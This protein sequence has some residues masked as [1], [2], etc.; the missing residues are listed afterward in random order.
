[1]KKV[2]NMLGLL[3]AMHICNGQ[4]NIFP[5]D[6]NVGIGTTNPENT[7]N[8]DRVLEVKGNSHA[9]YL[10]ST[11]NVISGLWSHDLGFYQAPAG[12]IAGTF[13][14]HPFSL[15]TNKVNRLTITSVGNVGIGIATPN[16]RFEVN[17]N[18][19]AKE[20]KVEV[21]NWPDY[22]F[23]TAYRL[24]PLHKVEEFIA[25]NGHLPEVPSAKEVE[26]NDVEVGANQA[27]LLKKIEELTLH[28]IEMEKKIS[29]QEEKISQQAAEIKKLNQSVK[30]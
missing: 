3:L 8:W 27:V 30:F 23:N 4:T 26:Q 20:V 5:A 17:G 15:I 19:R 24:M 21:A 11:H 29:G 12:G 14:N 9:K 6:G 18:I 1:M 25:E 2:L 16:E 28:L 22:V 10:A 13:T 7:E